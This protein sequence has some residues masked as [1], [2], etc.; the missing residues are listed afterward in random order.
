[1]SKKGFTIKEI[2]EELA[3]ILGQ[4]AAQKYT[5]SVSMTIHFRDGGIGKV[6]ITTESTLKKN[7]DK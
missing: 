7:F 4:Q 3:I 1:M 6:G 5:G 2:A